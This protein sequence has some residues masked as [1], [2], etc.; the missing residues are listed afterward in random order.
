MALDGFVVS[1]AQISI[2]MYLSLVLYKTVSF[3]SSNTLSIN[4]LKIND[5]REKDLSD[6]N[7]YTDRDSKRTPQEHK[8]QTLQLEPNFSG[9]IIVFS[10]FRG[11]CV[12]ID[13]VWIYR[14]LIHTTRNYKYLQRYR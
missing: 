5:I 13:G 12:T 10:R 11:V 6:D 14:P 4:T 3:S 7:K 9:V 1:S 8:G 2:F